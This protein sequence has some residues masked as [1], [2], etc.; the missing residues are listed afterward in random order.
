MS[1][2]ICWQSVVRYDNDYKECSLEINFTLGEV[3]IRLKEPHNGS[4]EAKRPLPDYI[5]L[6]KVSFGETLSIF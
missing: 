5:T 1:I 3:M 6:H 4:D 2:L